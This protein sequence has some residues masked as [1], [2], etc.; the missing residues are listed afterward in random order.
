MFH[1]LNN[2][3]EIIFKKLTTLYKMYSLFYKESVNKKQK[4]NLVE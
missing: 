3:R 2:R 4:F 1:D